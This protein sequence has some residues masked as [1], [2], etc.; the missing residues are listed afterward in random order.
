MKY[1]IDYESNPKDED[2]HLLTE[3]IADYAE[4]QGG[5]KPIQQFAF[6]IRDEHR[7]IK[8]GCNG[9]MYYGCIY[10]DQLWVAKEL[11]HQGFGSKLMLAAEKLGKENGCLF[12][13]VNTMEWE[14]L[15]FYL[16][17]GYEIEF[18]RRSF[19]QGAVLYLLRK[20]F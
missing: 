15:D 6:F 3:G 12:A 18:Q 13:T 4:Q 20:N 8:G 9:A 17:L 19:L 2:I 5:H 7:R 16:Q 10:I 14:A 1:K 11:R